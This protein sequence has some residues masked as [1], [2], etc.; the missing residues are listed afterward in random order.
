M[1]SIPR[2]NVVE[3][4]T[5]FRVE[6]LGRTGLLYVEGDRSLRVSSEVTAGPGGMIV[7][8]ESIKRWNAPYEHESIDA[9]AKSRIIENIRAAF[10]FRGFDI[11]VL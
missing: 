10:K 4:D 5:G 9:A 7:Y 2:I 8:S 11:D 1:F 3:S 6:V